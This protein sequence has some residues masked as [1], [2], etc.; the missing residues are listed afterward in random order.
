MTAQS[1]ELSID[2][3]RPAVEVELRST[4]WLQRITI[5]H[6][7]YAILALTAL[8]IRLVDL[9]LRPLAP[10][11]AGTALRAW[12]ISR[13][14]EPVLDA[15]TPLLLSLD[16]ATFFMTGAA[17]SLVRLWPLLASVGLV[18][19]V[20]Y[21]RNWLGRWI[22]LVAAILISPFA[23]GQRFRATRG[24]HR[25]GAAGPGNCPGRL[26]TFVPR[27]FRRL[28]LVGCGPGA[29][30]DQRARRPHRSSG[31]GYR[32]APDLAHG[33]TIVF[34]RHDNPPHIPGGGLVGRNDLP[35]PP[36]WAGIDSNQLER[37]VGRLLSFAVGMAL[38]IDP[39]GIG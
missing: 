5:E 32:T 24:R 27:Q 10:V 14:L 28:D 8:V 25:F 4:P 2:V 39:T 20:Y 37:V 6:L 17:S 11:E 18:I 35:H 3:D 9:G 29:R 12:Q 30:F 23:P 33:P 7:I 34:T 31:S 26:G 19:A 1:P 38:G 36:Y 15:G 22:T 16:V 21:W 13:G